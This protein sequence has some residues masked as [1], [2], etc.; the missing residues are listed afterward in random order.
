MNGVDFVKDTYIP[1]FT[2]KPD[3]YKEWRQRI[4]LYKRKSDLNKK[5]KEATI[6]LMTS[7]S[8]IAWKQI[9]GT[10]E[11]AAESEEGFMMILT[12]LDKT[13]KYDDQVEMPR[14]FERFFFGPHRREGQTMINYVAD[15]REALAEVEKHGISIADKVAGWRRAGLSTGQKQMVQGRASAFTQVSVV[16]A[17]YFLFGQDYKGR[18]SDN[19]SWKSGKGYGASRW[20]GN[21]NYMVEDAYEMD[22]EDWPDEP[23]DDASTWEQWDD[24]AYE[25]DENYED[26]YYTYILEENDLD[27]EHYAEAEQH[28]EEIYAT[29]LDARRQMANMKASRGFYPV[30]ALADNTSLPSSPS[31]QAP[32]PPKSKGKGKSKK[33]RKGPS[34]WQSKGGQIQAR[35]Q[36]ASKCL[37]CGQTG[38]WAANCPQ[39]STR[40]SPTSKSTNA[41]PSHSPSKKAKTDGTV[42]MVRDMAKQ[43]ATGLPDLSDSGWYGIQ[44]GGAS[45]VVVAYAHHGPHDPTWTFC[46]SLPLYGNRQD[47]WFWW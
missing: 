15:H 25:M 21:Q 2:N 33:G 46:G 32:R 5:Q 18:A 38:H 16:E 47:V 23:D 19:K 9:E 13:F 12:E 34:T 17:L 20:S 7:L 42:M 35:G 30:V 44:D 41:S 45:S 4:L 8:G 1:I 26:G 22:D 29:Y 24:E 40:S 39:G 3:D 37:R 10:D 36:A 6:N 43:H 11:K 28:Y 14:A 27:D 31:S